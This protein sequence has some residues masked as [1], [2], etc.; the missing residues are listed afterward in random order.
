MSMAAAASAVRDQPALIKRYQARRL[1]FLHALRTWAYFGKGWARRVAGIEAI[2]TKWALQ[3]AG[4]PPEIVQH[5]LQ[6]ES[7]KANRKAQASGAAS[8]TAPAAPI[9]HITLIDHSS[10]LHYAVDIA[11]VVAVGA[12]VAFLLY[13]CYVHALRANALERASHG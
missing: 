11:L 7:S 4:K 9:A 13:A 10:W 8:A 5:T 2:A 1:S 12:T 6:Q 3:A